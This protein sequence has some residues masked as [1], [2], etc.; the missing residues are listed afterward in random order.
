MERTNQVL[1]DMLRACALKMEEV[2]IRACRSQSFSYNNRYQA[3]L[4]DGTVRGIV[5]QEVQNSVVLE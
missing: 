4:K 3:S 1:E 2:G 5:W